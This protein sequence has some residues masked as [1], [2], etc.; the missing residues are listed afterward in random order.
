MLTLL[1]DVLVVSSQGQAWTIPKGF[2]SDGASVP[3]GL[4]S[5]FPPLDHYAPCALVHDQIC[6]WAESQGSKKARKQGDKLFYGLLLDYGIKK[7]RAKPMYY[8]VRLQARVLARKG[9]LS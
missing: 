6:I 2:V 9:I 7:W 3:H 1:E 5:L 4:W 8:A